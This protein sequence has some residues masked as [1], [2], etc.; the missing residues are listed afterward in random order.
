MGRKSINC[1][2]TNFPE[3]MAPI[4]QIIS[5]NYGQKLISNSII[6]FVIQI[7]SH[8]NWLNA[9]NSISCGQQLHLA[10]KSNL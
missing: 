8:S 1:E 3:Y 5:R 10:T 6:K 4:L 7:A 2:N 9:L